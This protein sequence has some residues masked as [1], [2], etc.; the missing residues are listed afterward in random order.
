MQRSEVP[1]GHAQ[2]G[3]FEN[4]A[5]HFRNMDVWTVGRISVEK[6]S[7]AFCDNVAEIIKHFPL[8]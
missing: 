7:T 2:S 6:T 5:W 1:C 4:N 3:N 8:M